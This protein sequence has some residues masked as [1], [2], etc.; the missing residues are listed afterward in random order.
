MFAG[1]T[2]V[3][4]N[5]ETKLVDVICEEEVDEDVLLGA[6]KNWGDKAGKSVER[7]QE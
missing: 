7:L 5:V 3:K 1:V 4:T 6:L 2:E